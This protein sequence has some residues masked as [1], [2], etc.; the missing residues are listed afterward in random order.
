[1][2]SASSSHPSPYV[3]ELKDRDTRG[4]VENFFNKL[5]E[6]AVDYV[7][8]L[9]PIA[10][11][12]GRY[13]LSWFT[14]DIIAGLTVGA[15][16][17]PQGMGYAQTAKLP[18]EYGLYSSFVGVTLYFLFSTSKDIT[19]GP[20]AVM[21][22]L[23][24]Q[25]LAS[26]TGGSKT[27]AYSNQQ[28]AASLAFL[29][30]IIALGIG[31]FRL[32]IVTNLISAPVITGFT[33]GSAVTIAIGQVPKLL[34]IKGIDTTQPSYLVAVNTLAHLPDSKKD[35]Y[36][37][38]FSLLFLYILKFGTAHFSKR[39]PKFERFFF[40]VGILRIGFVVLITTLISYLINKNL[41]IDNLGQSP[42]SILKKIPKGFDHLG[43]PV[44]NKSML[45]YIGGYVPSVTLI[46]VLEHIAIAKSFGRVNDYTIQ[47]SQELIAIGMTN[48]F[49][50][51][52][53]AYPSTGSFSRSA[54]KSKA[55]VRTPLAG[56]FS[57]VLV[58]LALFVLTPAFA[59]IPDACLSAVV[60]HAVL[61]LISPPS[62]L[63]KLWHIQFWDFAVFVVGLVFTIFFTVEIGVYASAGLSAAVLFVRL[64]RPRFNILGR[65]PTNI[66]NEGESPKYAYVPLRKAFSHAERPPDGV[67]VFRFEEGLTY[68][69]ANYIDD[70]VV[71][72]AKANTRRMA[73]RAEKFGD[74]PWNDA[75]SKE[76]DARIEENAK[77]PQLKAAV[78]D[79]TA[80]SMIDSTGIN[81]LLDIKKA[82]NKHAAKRIEF[83]FANIATAS[84][85]RSLIECG[86]GTEEVDKFESLPG[87]LENGEVKNDDSF[88][89]RRP[90]KFFHLSLEEAIS[91]ATDGEW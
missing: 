87:D 45:S 8:S 40:F 6:N 42:I 17:I 89:I 88:S 51:F 22:L 41:S 1:M 78:F 7:Q 21:S 57:G 30:G 60:I 81:S 77:L 55:G 82:L 25:T 12:I 71:E 56:V 85:Q 14:G 29:S 10:K 47:P 76:E 26:I 35:A 66:P 16:V 58:L 33:T 23:I 61:D 27:F 70:K 3:Y 31:L 62:Y 4:Q 48:V 83:H 50:S 38:L 64:A 37:G 11:W 80:V 2:S 18:P 67:L 86:F 20:T 91:A 65:I 39:H 46:L 84:I 24:G 63:I 32:G 19:I 15:V 43:P 79:L 68:P 73:R 13:N 9:F 75:G 54:I 72:Y 59:Y 28:L 74:R 5:P 69:N 34:G 44:L 49:G 53:G 90:K 52:F 36:V